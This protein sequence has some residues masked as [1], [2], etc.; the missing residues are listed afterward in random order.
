MMLLLLGVALVITSI[1]FYR[2]LYFINI[3]YAF[4]IVGMV[5]VTLIRY[6]GNLSLVSVLQNVFLILWGLRLG[7]YVTKREFQAAYSKQKREIHEGLAGVPW[8]IKIVIWVSVSILYVLMFL[9]SLFRLIELP[10]TTSW[11]LH[12]SQGAGLFLMGSGLILEAIADKQKSDFKAVHPKQYCDVGLY[13]WIRCPNYFGEILFWVGNWV[14]GIMF[15]TTSIQWIASLIGVI[16]IVWIMMG[17]TKRLEKAQDGR[18]GDRPEYQQYIRSVPVLFPFVPVYS[19][20]EI[21]VL[22]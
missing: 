8:G 14:V 10:E 12:F 22:L 15:Y 19:L 7:I 4:A 21:R 13:R 18:Y 17:S 9:P 11:I 1:G 6:V 5:I 3:G 2:L 16:C 20:K